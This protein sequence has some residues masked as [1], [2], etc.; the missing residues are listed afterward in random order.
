VRLIRKFALDRRGATAIEY[1]LILALIFVVIM[2]AVHT[3]A[4]KVIGT[5]TSVSNQVVNAGNT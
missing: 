4:G 1:G 3:L 2:V 5:W